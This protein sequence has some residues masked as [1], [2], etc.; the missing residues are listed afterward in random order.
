MCSGTPS[1]LARRPHLV[2]G[3][4]EPAEPPLVLPSCRDLSPSN[5]I[6]H[7]VLL[8]ANEPAKTGA[9]ALRLPEGSAAQWAE[10]P[11]SLP[12]VGGSRTTRGGAGTV[13][14]GLGPWPQET[15][16]KIS[17]PDVGE[18]LLLALA[19]LDMQAPRKAC[20]SCRLPSP[21][22]LWASFQCVRNDQYLSPGS[23]TPTL[24]GDLQL[25][26]SGAS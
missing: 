12:P 10:A 13:G 11:R 25:R 19:P 21:V 16:S 15:V 5:T 9:G 4:G 18:E 7:P 3:G 8:R 23:K 1:S 22:F 14:L 2:P 17:D 6:L 26:G 24:L 20:F